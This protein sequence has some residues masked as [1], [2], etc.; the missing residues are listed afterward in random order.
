M[1]DPYAKVQPGDEVSFSAV[2]WNAMVDAGRALKG[3]MFGVQTPAPSFITSTT[4]VPVLNTTGGAL[5]R[6]SVLG[7]GDPIFT[8]DEHSVD[9]FLR[10][11]TF[12]G[13]IPVVGT[14]DRKYVILIEPAP[15]NQVVRG[16]IAG[17][18]PVLIDQQDHT[19]E[20]ARIYQTTPGKMLSSMHG[21]ARILWREGLQGSGY[22]YYDGGV[23]WAVVMLGV[24]GASG[25]VGKAA[26]TITPKAGPVF[27]S[28][29]VDIYRNLQGSEDGPLETIQVSNPGSEISVGKWV[30]YEYD[31]FDVPWVAPLECEA[32]PYS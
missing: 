15:A 16:C 23:Q 32:D 29:H 8:P 17:V 3:Q 31:A 14:H 6:Y 21:H 2:T 13:V 19:H 20:C 26:S 11:V 1:P 18:C 27:G 28:G 24:T 25:G 22:G 7:L 9:I 5:A 12:R 30:A 10:G 4:I